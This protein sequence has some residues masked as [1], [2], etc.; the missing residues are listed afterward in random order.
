M[1]NLFIKDAEERDLRGLINLL[2]D[3][4]LGNQK[5][6]NTNPP[7]QSYKN[8][9]DEIQSDTNNK[10]IIATINDKIIGMMQITF[11]PSLS[12]KGSKRCQIESVRIHKDYRNK[13]FGKK[14]IGK[15][16]EMAMKKKCSIV[17]LTSNKKRKDAI[18]FYKKIGF[19]STHQSFK[20]ELGK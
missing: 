18:K 2:Y 20:L 13:G 7:I 11:I 12:I 3:D 9:F 15:G 17:Q 19:S 6:D 8:A 4:D 5:E 10:I 14:L 1:P 16:I